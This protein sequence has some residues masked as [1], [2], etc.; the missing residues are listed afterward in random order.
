[1]YVLYVATVNI[2]FQILND[3]ICFFCLYTVPSDPNFNEAFCSSS[4]IIS[5]T[6][7]PMLSTS[8]SSSMT[9]QI[10][11]NNPASE[12][13][14]ATILAVLGTHILVI[15]ILVTSLLMFV[16][17]RR[18]YR[19]KNKPNTV[20]IVAFNRSYEDPDA[21]YD[22]I[23]L[24]NGVPVDVDVRGRLRPASV[25]NVGKRPVV[26]EISRVCVYM[27]AVIL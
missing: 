5:S 8:I 18:H 6:S 17:L 4:D 10:G 26:S 22:Y 13:P 16:I 2:V 25:K 15:V 14:T 11:N 1:M 9:I 23:V 19:S 21:D 3:I 20:E 27:H 24:S 7:T 12:S